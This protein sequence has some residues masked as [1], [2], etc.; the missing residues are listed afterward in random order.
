MTGAFSDKEKLSAIVFVN[1]E[2]SEILMRSSSGRALLLHTGAIASKTTRNTQ[3]V[4]VFKQRKGHRLIS[5]ELYHEGMLQ[6]PQRYRT[7]SFPSS[8][9]LPTAEELE[10]EQLELK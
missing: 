10:G 5:A 1:D 6:K 2:D 4:A 8:G 7:K 9:A 3:G